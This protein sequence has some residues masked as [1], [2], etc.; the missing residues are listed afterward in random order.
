V[1]KKEQRAESKGHSAWREGGRLKLVHTVKAAVEV[2]K[3]ELIKIQ[4]RKHENA[5]NKK[6]NFNFRVGLWMPIALKYTK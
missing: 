3:A 1:G 6:L 2:W 5:K 4:S